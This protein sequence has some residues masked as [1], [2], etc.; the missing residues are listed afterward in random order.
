MLAA[1]CNYGFKPRYRRTIKFALWTHSIT[2]P[3]DMLARAAASIGFGRQVIDDDMPSTVY[4]RLLGS[5]PG[6]TWSAATL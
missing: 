3:A 1:E 4:A 5:E 2:P 6:L